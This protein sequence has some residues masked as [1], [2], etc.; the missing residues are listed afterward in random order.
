MLDPD[1]SDT[2]APEGTQKWKTFSL[3]IVN[4]TWIFPFYIQTQVDYFWRKKVSPT[5]EVYQFFLECVKISFR[6][7]L[8]LPVGVARKDSDAN[9][10]TPAG[11]PFDLVMS[12]ANSMNYL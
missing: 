3:W 12:F 11:L 9:K 8:S 6:N 10:K 5:G 7:N 1:S 4:L 2:E